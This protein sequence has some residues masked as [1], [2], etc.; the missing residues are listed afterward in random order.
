MARPMNP[1]QR[2]HLANKHNTNH[3]WD[4]VPD[5]GEVM[6]RPHLG[7]ALSNLTNKTH[8]DENTN[9]VNN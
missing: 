5:L 6:C 3:Q 4:V 1:F 7:S 9:T 8:P 2:P